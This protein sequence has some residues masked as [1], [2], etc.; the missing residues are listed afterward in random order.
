MTT[1]VFRARPFLFPEIPEIPEIEPTDIEE[2]ANDPEVVNALEVFHDAFNGGEIPDEAESIDKYNAEVESTGEDAVAQLVLKVLQKI[3]VS[4]ITS[5]DQIKGTGSS[6]TDSITLTE[7]TKATVDKVTNGEEIRP[8]ETQALVNDVVNTN[9]P[10]AVNEISKREPSAQEASTATEEITRQTLENIASKDP[11]TKGGWMEILKKVVMFL[12]GALQGLVGAAGLMWVLL[13]IL[14][15][16]MTGCYQYYDKTK[17]RKLNC[18]GF[19]YNSDENRKFCTC[20][21]SDA[22]ITCDDSLARYLVDPSS[23]RQQIQTACREASSET[24]SS[25]IHTD[26]MF[27]NNPLCKISN[28]A[29]FDADPLVCNLNDSSVYYSFQKW[30][31]GGLLSNIIDNWPNL[32]SDTG[33]ALVRFLKTAFIALAILIGLFVLYNISKIVFRRL[34]YRVERNNNNRGRLT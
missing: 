29:C 25:C 15:H 11:P 31:W 34:N 30:D 28:S 17:S 26:D 32:F 13:K 14:A 7:S 8:E 10:E 6:I 1:T 9:I 33:S 18:P 24:S 20:L 21:P 2:A 5:I 12:L 27:Q 3:G 23:T 4:D 22:P 19:D 16:A